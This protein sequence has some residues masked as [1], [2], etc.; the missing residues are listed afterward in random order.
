[1]KSTIQ[2]LRYPH[3][4]GKLQVCHK[5][6]FPKSWGVPPFLI[7][8]QT[9][10]SIKR[11][12]ISQGLRNKNC[13][14]AHLFPA[15]FSVEDLSSLASAMRGNNVAL[16]NWG[17]TSCKL[18]YKSQQ[19]YNHHKP[20]FIGVMKWLS[21]CKRG[22]VY[23]STYFHGAWG[24]RVL[25]RNM[26]LP[27]LC[28][29]YRQAFAAHAVRPLA[30]LQGQSLQSPQNHPQSRPGLDLGDLGRGNLSWLGV[31]CWET[32]R[33]AHLDISGSVGTI[34][35]D[36]DGFFLVKT[37]YGASNDWIWL[38]SEIWNPMILPISSSHGSFQC[39][40]KN[41]VYSVHSTFR[42]NHRIKLQTLLCSWLWASGAWN[43]DPSP[44]HDR[45][46][47]LGS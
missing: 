17:P 33:N 45:A 28:S 30:I 7:Q 34:S 32:M 25:E 40:G 2:L 8:F 21:Y 22:P 29:V 6:R 37:S 5:W 24:P 36:S 44:G 43:C 10:C 11:K 16:T 1:M 12:F 35:L 27:I 42:W 3:G 39:V 14:V 4:F 26:P 9:G 18:I 20:E 47:G 38:V 23:C 46:L 19:L 15:V 31:S 13:W 41:E